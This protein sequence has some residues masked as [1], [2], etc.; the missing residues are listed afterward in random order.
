MRAIAEENPRLACVIDIL[1]FN[2]T[3]ARQRTLDDDNLGWA[4]EYL[5]AGVRC[6][7]PGEAI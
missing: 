5:L 7:Q 4:Y 2:A 6:R 3:A 1:D